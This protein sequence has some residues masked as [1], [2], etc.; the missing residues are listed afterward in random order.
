MKSP[1]EDAEEHTSCGLGMSSPVRVRLVVERDAQGEAV[2]ACGDGEGVG[3]DEWYIA[4]VLVVRLETELSAQLIFGAEA[5]ATVDD[6]RGSLGIALLETAQECERAAVC[7]FASE[8]KPVGGGRRRLL[9]RTALLAARGG[10]ADEA[11]E[12]VDLVGE[13]KA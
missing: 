3:A 4:A 6:P 10:G 13:A 12:V 11:C 1:H 2:A 9:A 7:I 8:G 5:Q